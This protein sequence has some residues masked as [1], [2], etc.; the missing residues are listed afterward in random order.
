M[1]WKF[2]VIQIILNWQI[3][4]QTVSL[5]DLFKDFKREE[6]SAA[7]LSVPQKLATFIF[8]NLF[9]DDSELKIVFK[10][11]QQSLKYII[12]ILKSGEI[13]ETPRF[14]RSHPIVTRGSVTPPHHTLPAFLNLNNKISYDVNLNLKPI[15]VRALSSDESKSK[16]WRY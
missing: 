16:K 11:Y 4:K 6:R 5:W 10:V 3:E 7:L 15:I 14:A 1:T 9:I 13:R 8:A 12:K 2:L